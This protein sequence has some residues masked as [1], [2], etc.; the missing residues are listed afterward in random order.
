MLQT[1]LYNISAATVE[2][3][4][5]NSGLPCAHDNLMSE[6]FEKCLRLF[7]EV[8]TAFYIPKT[9]EGD[10]PPSLQPR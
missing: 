1:L 10:V 4:I 3:H 6:V 8:G 9:R 5:D 2:K 7:F